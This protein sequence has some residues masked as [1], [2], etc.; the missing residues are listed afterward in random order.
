MHISTP[1]SYKLW[2]YITFQK[3]TYVWNTLTVQNRSEKISGTPRWIMLDHQMRLQWQQIAVTEIH[4]LKKRENSNVRIVKQK[5]FCNPAFLLTNYG[6]SQIRQATTAFVA[7]MIF[8]GANNSKVHEV[9]GGKDAHQLWAPML[10]FGITLILDV[11]ILLFFVFGIDTGVDF[12]EEN[13]K[14]I[15]DLKTSVPIAFGLLQF[16]SLLL[17]S[18]AQSN[19]TLIFAMLFAFVSCLCHLFPTKWMPCK[20]RNEESSD[21]EDNENDYYP[22][23]V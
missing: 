4:W 23:N 14:I 3:Q 19:A 15:K 5:Q 16:L 13:P 17:V 11:F 6:L 2:K 10:A 18:T 9:L 8:I 20:G 21:Q 22:E 1:G 7:L 12:F